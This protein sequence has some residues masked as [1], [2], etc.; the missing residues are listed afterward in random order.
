MSFDERLF[1]HKDAP[2]GSAP[3]SCTQFRTIK[4]NVVNLFVGNYPWHLAGVFASW[5][6][7]N[8]QDLMVW[9]GAGLLTPTFYCGR[10]SIKEDCT[11]K[12]SRLDNG[13]MPRKCSQGDEPQLI[14]WI[15]IQQ[16]MHWR[17]GGQISPRTWSL[18]NHMASKLPQVLLIWFCTSVVKLL[19]L[20]T[21]NH[22][23]TSICSRIY[24][25]KLQN[26]ASEHTSFV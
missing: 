24:T 15:I 21:F 7:Y 2:V 19:Q 5:W 23:S 8:A 25:F 14:C 26:T 1:I 10:T 18:P 11:L 16:H 20:L 22:A 3:V 4:A 13:D 6:P 17:Y 12:S 9:Y